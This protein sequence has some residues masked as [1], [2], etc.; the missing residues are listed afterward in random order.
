VDTERLHRRVAIIRAVRSFFDGQGFLEVDTPVAVTAPAPEAHIEAPAVTLHT[1]GRAH[2]R[3]LQTSPELS[4]KRLL[5]GG[6]DRIYQ[7]APVFRDADFSAIHR[8]EFRLL[9]WYRKHSSWDALLDDCE[10][11]LRACARAAGLSDRF[12]YQA[13]EIDLTGP[14]R[15]IS[16]DEA[17]RA[18][19]GFSILDALDPARLRAELDA[20]GLHSV[21]DDSWDDLFHRVFLS[22][23]EPVILADPRPVFLTHYPAPLA[24]LARL[25]PKDPRA[26]ERF[27]LFVGDM[28]LAN[29]FGELVDADLQRRR[30]ERDRETRRQAGFNDYPLDERFL[31]ALASLPPSAGIALGVDRLL[32]LL[33]DVDDIDAVGFIPWSES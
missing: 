2:R 14:F 3:F 17:F 9:E 26:S 18:H 12:R 5:V 30:F 22:K 21:A 33:L 28:E 1:E 19:A 32:M 31:A 23:I 8:P 7:I 25:D 16:M 10:G 4:M 15:R 13:R 20:V 27:E 29:G 11:L 6:L 24:A